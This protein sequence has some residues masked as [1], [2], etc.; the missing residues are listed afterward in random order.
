MPNRIGRGYRHYQD[1]QLLRNVYSVLGQSLN[2]RDYGNPFI[3][4]S[5]ALRDPE[6]LLRETGKAHGAHKL[7]KD[8]RNY[9]KNY[10]NLRWMQMVANMFFRR[11]NQISESWLHGS[12]QRQHCDT[13]VTNDMCFEDLEGLSAYAKLDSC[14][15]SSK[16]WAESACKNKHG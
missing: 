15:S 16:S 7:T 3:S 6:T 8:F 2:S 14:R 9:C 11:W 4:L 5:N 13:G 12:D 10:T 1:I